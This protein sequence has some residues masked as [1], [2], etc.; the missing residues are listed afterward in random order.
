MKE[1]IQ[2][3]PLKVE[4]MQTGIP[5]IW[6]LIGLFT[7]LLN[8]LPPQVQ[9]LVNQWLN[10]CWTYI[11][12]RFDPYYHLD[13]P[14]FNGSYGANSNEAY[15]NVELYLPGLDV[16][17]GARR[18]TVFCSKNSNCAEFCPA[19]EE[20]V[21]DFFKGT[22]IW[23][24]H[25]IHYHGKEDLME[26]RWFTLK[27]AKPTKTFLSQYFDHIADSAAELKRLNRGKTLYTNNRGGYGG[28]GTG[29]T[30][31]PF[32]HP[33]TF[34]SLAL[35]PT[36]KAKIIR[37]LDRFKQGKE[38]HSRVGRPWK[39]GYLLYGPPG[40]G[41]SSLVAAMANYMKYNVYDLEL[42]KVKDNS[43]LR[44]L[45]IQ[46]TN[47]SMIVIEDIDCSLDL[48][49]RISKP[50]KLDNGNGNAAAMDDHEER[51]GSRITLSGILNFTDGLWS[52]C[53]EERIIVFTTNHKD[54]LD[55][56]LMR[57]GRMDMHIH[58]SFCAF[59][60]FKCLAFNYLQIEDH[61]L[62]SSV[63]ESMSRGAQMTPADI[64]EI[65]IDNL[66]DPF[67]ALSA[68]ISALNEKKP[69]AIPESLDPHEAVEEII[70]T[71]LHI[72]GEEGIRFRGRGVG[73]EG[74]TVV[75]PSNGCD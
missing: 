28:G 47:K 69:S 42:T 67:N 36:L 11:R 64:S 18:L 20:A 58:L 2:L 33:S 17:E 23:W 27:V 35:D 19:S 40:T 38:F 72:H 53:G 63:E 3:L 51:S 48:S 30:G 75:K 60:A 13:I 15:D 66:D 16:M 32:K 34:E 55:P 65:L 62:F 9:E 50:P 21:V 22:T 52:C 68:V 46:T 12:N 56:A 8:I 74:P 26:R 4:K 37:D 49:N 41:K 10:H 71:P 73:H 70:P 25:H 7:L 39:R 6:S 14:E 61:P 44:T 29:W 57:S 1:S 43:E 45:L 24:S 54:R 5:Q 59:P 31:V